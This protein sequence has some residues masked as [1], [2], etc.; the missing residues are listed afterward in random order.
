MGMQGFFTIATGAT[1]DAALSNALE[2]ENA[3][4]DDLPDSIAQKEACVE[5]APG[6]HSEAEADALYEK[7]MYDARFCDSWG[8]TACV[9]LPSADTT[10]R[11]FALFGWANT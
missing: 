2:S 1:P 3:E 5:V 11:R 8:P 4:Q 6:V 7:F 10:E 9:E